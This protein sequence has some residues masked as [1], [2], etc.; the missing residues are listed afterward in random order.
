MRSFLKILIKTVFVS[1]YAILV[2]M[3]VKLTVFDHI[4]FK[5][6]I[7]RGVFLLFYLF[8]FNLNAKGNA[9]FEKLFEK[10]LS[11]YFNNI[12]RLVLQLIVVTLWPLITII[13]PFAIWYDINGGALSYPPFS[14]FLFI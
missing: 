11:P 7:N 14:M 2:I 8:L 13:L 9:Y 5:P 3:L 1:L 6:Q 12:K 4:G 10:S